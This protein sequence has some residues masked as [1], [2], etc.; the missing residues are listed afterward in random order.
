MK[1]LMLSAATTAKRRCEKVEVA[2]IINPLVF[3]S[4]GPSAG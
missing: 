2:V 4:S 3:R 1:V